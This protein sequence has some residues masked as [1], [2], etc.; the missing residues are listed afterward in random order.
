MMLRAAVLLSMQQAL[1][2]LVTPGLRAV[3]VRWDGG[4]IAARFLF[5][6]DPGEED[7]ADLSLAETRVVADFTPEH[8]V[9]FTA[10]W[11]PRPMA[12]LLNE[13]EEW[14]YLRKERT[15]DELIVEEIVSD[16][17]EELKDDYVELWALPWRIRRA[18]PGV[19]DERVHELGAVILKAL[20]T[21]AVMGNLDGETGR[22]HPWSGDGLEVAMSAWRA[23][24]RDPNMGDI[25]WIAALPLDD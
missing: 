17:R 15:F 6:H 4:V 23:L 12:L 18:F 20:L 19:S 2:G 22:F 3:A 9:E 10:N 14:V 11:L 13:G 7:R 25:G 8:A 16:F 1:R 24:G 5:D 21:D